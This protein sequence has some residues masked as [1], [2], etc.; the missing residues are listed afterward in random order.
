MSVA[1]FHFQT[2][3]LKK[4]MEMCN[5]F[6]AGVWKWPICLLPDFNSRQRQK[7]M[8]MCNLFGQVSGSDQY[9]CCQ[10]PDGGG[11]TLPAIPLQYNFKPNFCLASRALKRKILWFWTKW[12]NYR[13][14]PS[15]HC[16]WFHSNTTSNS[17]SNQ[18]SVLTQE[19]WIETLYNFGRNKR[20]MDLIFEPRLKF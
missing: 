20:F 5:L 14:Q 9:V 1:R 13:F 19:P 11:P 2:E 7:N 17:T 18:M 12:K 10:A 16:D 15:L 4:N 3:T 8:E 6:E